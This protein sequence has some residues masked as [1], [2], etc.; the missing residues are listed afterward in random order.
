MTAYVKR[1]VSYNEKRK[2]IKDAKVDETYDKISKT[3]NL[4]LYN[5]LLDKLTSHPYIN[6][7]VLQKQAEFLKEKRDVFCE[8]SV[9]NQCA[10]LLE[11]LHFMQCNSATSNLS[12]LG[13]N[14]TVGKLTCNKKLSETGECLLITQ[15]PTGYYKNI[16]N[17]TAY[18]RQ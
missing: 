6:F 10:L 16:V 3:S 13:G 11:I 8:L 15:S 18:Y 5:A 12:L 4:T 17:L 7:S 1:I 14:S 9:E 2:E